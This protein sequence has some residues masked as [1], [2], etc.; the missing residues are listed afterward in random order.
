[1]IELKEEVLEI[2]S[3]DEQENVTGGARIGKYGGSLNIDVFKWLGSWRL[4]V[5]KYVGKVTS[6]D[7]SE[8][9]GGGVT[10]VKYNGSTV[11]LTGLNRRAKSKI[12]I[13]GKKNN[14]KYYMVLYVSVK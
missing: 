3:E 2:L 7:F 6:I 12:I 5:S 9:R 14:K 1:M 11:I 4:N 8:S 13:N 10:R